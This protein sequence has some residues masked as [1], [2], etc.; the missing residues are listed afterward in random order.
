VSF[1]GK[2]YMAKPKNTCRQKDISRLLRNK[3]KLTKIKSQSVRGK[4]T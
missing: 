4:K 2:E 1:I 3:K